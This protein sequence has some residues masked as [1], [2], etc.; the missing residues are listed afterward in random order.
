MILAFLRNQYLW[1]KRIFSDRSQ[2]CAE[3]TGHLVNEI[4]LSFNTMPGFYGQP[5]SALDFEL[6]PELQ[7]SLKEKLIGYIIIC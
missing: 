4:M 7:R 1:A 2:H 5:Y 6:L 3:R